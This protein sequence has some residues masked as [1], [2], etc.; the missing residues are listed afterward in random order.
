M[1]LAGLVVVAFLDRGGE[2][3]VDGVRRTLASYA[4]SD[5]QFESIGQCVRKRFAAF[6]IDIVTREPAHGPF[7]HVIFGGKA[8]AKGYD[9]ETV[10]GV[11]P[12][13][14]G[15]VQPDATVYVFSDGSEA[16]LTYLCGAAAH[17]VGHALGLDHSRTCY[18]LM[19]YCDVGHAREFVD[20][21][22][23]CGEHEDR[24]CY[25][26]LTLA[27]QNTYRKLAEALGLRH[28]AKPEDPYPVDKRTP[29]DPYR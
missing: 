22:G 18:D 19:S 16:K 4:G 1:N 28:E 12:S 25:G 10:G 7:I 29:V 20:V 21:D 11:A 13:F 23:P 27:R 3:A 8:S 17:E 2:I 14:D 5:A 15:T 9:D 6:D 26:A 24:S